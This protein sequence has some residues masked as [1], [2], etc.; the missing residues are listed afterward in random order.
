MRQS[1]QTETRMGYKSFSRFITSV[2]LGRRSHCN[3][4]HS[5]TSTHNLSSGKTSAG[6]RGWYVLLITV[7]ET[8]WSLRIWGKGGRSVKIWWQQV[9]N[10]LICGRRVDTNLD[11][12]ASKSVD[13]PC[14]A[15]T[16]ARWTCQPLGTPGQAIEQSSGRRH[17]SE[18]FVCHGLWLTQTLQG[19]TYD[20]HLQGHWSDDYGSIQVISA[21]DTD[22]YAMYIAMSNAWFEVVVEKLPH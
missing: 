11:N 19:S 7:F 9:S 22:T 18:A 12:C 16:V 20:C 3:A 10:S 6:G 1:L 2:A 17:C 21:G 8:E 14:R 15:R 13:I 4:M 5:S